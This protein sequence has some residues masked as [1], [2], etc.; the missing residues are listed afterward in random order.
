MNARPVFWP[1]FTVPAFE[2]LFARNEDFTAALI[3]QYRT[4]TG[5][6]PSKLFPR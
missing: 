6:K 1:L 4:R 2:K 5:T 3:D